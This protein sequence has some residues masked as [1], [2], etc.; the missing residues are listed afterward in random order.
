MLSTAQAQQTVQFPATQPPDGGD[1]TLTDLVEVL[2][3]IINNS[4]IPVLIAVL[5]VF[6]IWKV[7]DTLILHPDD[8]QKR[9]DGKK[10]LLISVM[11]M[12]VIVAIWGIIA[13]IRLSIFGA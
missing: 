9:A 11:V 3:D 4:L 1:M 2:I 8:E 12:V 6:I 7:I 5:L 10:V 13:F